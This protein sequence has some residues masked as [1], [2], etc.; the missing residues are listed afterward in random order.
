MKTTAT[1]SLSRHCFPARKRPRNHNLEEQAQA[2]YKS[3]FT[4][5]EPFKDDKFVDS[6]LGMIPEG[7]KVASLDS[8][9]SII[10]RGFSPKYNDESDD[11]VLGQR[12]VRN[13]LI[14]I[15][16]ARR[17][18]P[19]NLGERELKK[20]DILINSTGFGS[21]GRVAQIYFTPNR[22]TFDSHLTLVRSKEEFSKQYIGRN[23]LSR[24]D[25]I[26]NLA[27]GST[28][29]TELP[30]ERVKALPIIVPTNDVMTSFGKKIKALNEL[31]QRNIEANIILQKGRDELLP[32]L[33]TGCCRL[34]N[35]AI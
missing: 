21:L 16:I 1:Y 3:W 22:L 31:I 34:A 8:L 35:N 14:D 6:E 32:R 11:L 23:L 33:M 24:Q 9:C 7:W 12:C 2:I 20:W 13:N 18:I 19:K 15:S 4:D 28:G 17:H 30:R 25:E 10:S 27:V 5:F 29:Q 26:E